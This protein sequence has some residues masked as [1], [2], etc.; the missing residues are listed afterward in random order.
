MRQGPDRMKPRCY[1]TTASALST[2]RWTEWAGLTEDHCSEPILSKQLKPTGDNSLGTQSAHLLCRVVLGPGL[3][4]GGGVS[5]DASRAGRVL[6]SE[7][8][9]LGDQWSL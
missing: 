1:R 6:H 5:G 3:G 4:Q 2:R 7:V 9:R 8:P